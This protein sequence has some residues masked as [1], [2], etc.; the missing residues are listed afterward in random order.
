MVED[1]EIQELIERDVYVGE[2]LVGVIVGERFHPRDEFVRSMRIQVDEGVASEYMRK[3]AECAP[4]AKELVHSIRSDGCVRLSKS[5]RELQRRWRNTV[6][7]ENQLYATDELLDRAVL[8]NDGMDIGNVV[9]LVKI[10]RTYKGLLVKPHF[11]VR[12]RHN[13]PEEIVVPCGQLAR[14][15]ARLD[16]VILKCTFSRMMTLPSYLKLNE[17][18]QD[19][20]AVT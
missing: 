20:R 19:D 3:A 10:K 7:I 6:R 2:K 17:L 12:S 8:D 18:H 4:L 1:Y 11:M 5:M 13:L 16:E 9:D 15:T 14:T